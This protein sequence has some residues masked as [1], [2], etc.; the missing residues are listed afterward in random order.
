MILD[1]IIHINK[2]ALTKKRIFSGTLHF[3]KA[4][5]VM[6][7]KCLLCSC[8][9]FLLVLMKMLTV[10]LNLRSLFLEKGNLRLTRSLNQELGFL[11]YTSSSEG[12]GYQGTNLCPQLCENLII[13]NGINL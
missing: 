6:D 2:V 4:A 11:E 12:I 1:G 13:Q 8:N 9:L 7:F 10:R 5:W 3:L